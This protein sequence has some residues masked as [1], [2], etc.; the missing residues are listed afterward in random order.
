[1][2]VGR[3][4]DADDFG[5]LAGSDAGGGRRVRESDFEA[6]AFPVAGA[7]DLD[8]QAVARD[9]NGFADFFKRF[10]SIDPTNVNRGGDFGAAAGAALEDWLV[11]ARR[12]VLMRLSLRRH[13]AGNSLLH[14]RTCITG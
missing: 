2:T 4:G 1:M 5:E 10:G 3:F 12:S 6:L 8:Q 13:L 7:G 14:L 9:V 11:G